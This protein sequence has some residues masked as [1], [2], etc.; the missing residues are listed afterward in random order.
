MNILSPD[1]AMGLVNFHIAT[2]PKTIAR[3]ATQ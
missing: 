3:S 2:K 1:R